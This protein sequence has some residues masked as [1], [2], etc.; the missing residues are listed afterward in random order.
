[1]SEI[2]D[3]CYV[4]IHPKTREAIAICEDD[5]SYSGD[6]AKFVARQIKRGLIVERH[7]R[8]IAVDMMI[9]KPEIKQAVEA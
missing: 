7:T 4:A 1:M 9:G 2:N 8:S 3:F 6:T 5:P